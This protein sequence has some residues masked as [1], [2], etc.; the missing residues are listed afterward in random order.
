LPRRSTFTVPITG[1]VS[2]LPA[3]TVTVFCGVDA[4]VPATTQRPPLH[5]ARATVSGA[6]RP[7]IVTVVVLLHTGVV[8]A[9]HTSSV[10]VS[11]LVVFGNVKVSFD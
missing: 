10:S 1:P 4:A 3:W 11:R 5:R 9:L 2:V 6:G 7:E 8:A